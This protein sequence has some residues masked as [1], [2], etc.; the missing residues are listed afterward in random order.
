MAQNR[1]RYSGRVVA[2]LDVMDTHSHEA[3]R[4]LQRLTEAPAG[5]A[6]SIIVSPGSL[7]NVPGLQYL[8][9]HGRHLGSVEIQSSDP[10]TV[11]E[12]HQALTGGLS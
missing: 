10:A 2:R 6:V 1:P 12:W 8:R 11:H 7:P 9:T 4:A 5:A 3:F